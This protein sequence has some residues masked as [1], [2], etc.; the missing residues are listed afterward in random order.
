MDGR[1]DIFSL[2]AVLYEMIAGRRPFAGATA[3]DTLAAI[4]RDE[5]SGSR[6][7]FPIVL[8]RSNGSSTGVSP[9]L[10]KDGIRLPASSPPS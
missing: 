5:P 10:P 3:G 6:T 4:L 8:R 1:S 9:K 7:I 2:G